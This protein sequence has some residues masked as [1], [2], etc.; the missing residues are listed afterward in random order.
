MVQVFTLAGRVV[1]YGAIENVTPVICYIQLRTR[2]S[3]L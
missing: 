3:L 2:I 1:E